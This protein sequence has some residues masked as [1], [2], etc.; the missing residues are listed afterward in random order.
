M[1]KLLTRLQGFEL[2]ANHGQGHAKGE[3]NAWSL[4]ERGRAVR[5]AIEIP[6][7]CI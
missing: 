4:T 1:S 7:A 6:Q 5:E 2:I 3:P